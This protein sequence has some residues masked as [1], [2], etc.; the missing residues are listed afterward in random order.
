MMELEN[1]LQGTRL[2]VHIAT[3]LIV[4]GYV[5]EPDSAKRPAVSW[6]AVVLAGGSAYL[7]ISTGLNWSQW[8]CLP[9]G[10]QFFLTIIF[11]AMLG[12]LIAGRGNVATLLPRKAWSHRP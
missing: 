9:I 5:P 4:A 1:L 3:L 10:A 7:A 6:L 11:A 8:Q 12:S 2:L